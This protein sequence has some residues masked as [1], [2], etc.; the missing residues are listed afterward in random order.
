MKT[1]CA[2]RSGAARGVEW[3]Q[4][5]PRAL[6]ATWLSARGATWQAWALLQ[7]RAP[8]MPIMPY[9]LAARR[10]PPPSPD[11]SRFSPVLARG[12]ARVCGALRLRVHLA[13]GECAVRTACL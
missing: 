12:V 4:P 11:S 2:A 3:L 9:H 10:G 1:A 6:S 13:L 5:E 7:L 8:T